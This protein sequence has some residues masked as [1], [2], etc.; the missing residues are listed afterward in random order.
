MAKELAM[1]LSMKNAGVLNREKMCATAF[2]HARKLCHVSPS[3][4][5]CVLSSDTC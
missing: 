5:E 3:F 1:S 2:G 4:C